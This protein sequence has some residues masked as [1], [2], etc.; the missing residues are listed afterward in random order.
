MKTALIIIFAM[1]FPLLFMFGWASFV[2]LE[3]AKQVVKKH[4]KSLLLS[5]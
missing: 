1:A 4:K 3:M 2:F 5:K